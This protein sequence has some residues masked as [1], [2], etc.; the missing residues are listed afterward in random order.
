MQPYIPP[1]VPQGISPELRR[2]LEEELAQIALLINY[3]LQYNED[4]P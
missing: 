2:F 3:L 4:N 1:P